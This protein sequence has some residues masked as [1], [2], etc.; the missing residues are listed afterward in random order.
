MKP[1]RF[2]ERFKYVGKDRP[3]HYIC[4][5]DF[6]YKTKQEPVSYTNDTLLHFFKNDYGLPEQVFKQNGELIL[7]P[8]TK[9]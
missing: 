2:K 7:Y 3:L 5:G 1:G 9:L 8:L 6:F 4:N